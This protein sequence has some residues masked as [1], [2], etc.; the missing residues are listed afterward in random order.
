MTH[1]PIDYTQFVRYAETE[2]PI[3]VV[4]IETTG[5]SMEHEIIELG[6]YDI[7]TGQQWSTYVKPERTRANDTA[8]I[9]GITDADVADAPSIDEA[10]ILLDERAPIDNALFVAHNGHYFDIPRIN[11]ARR[12][13]FAVNGEI[14]PNQV[15]DTL[16]FAHKV[17]PWGGI[18]NYKLQTLIDYYNIPGTQNHRAGDDCEYTAKVLCRLLDT[19]RLQSVP[20]TTVD[21]VIVMSERARTPTPKEKEVRRILISVHREMQR[22]NLEEDTRARLVQA[23]EDMFYNCYNV[24]PDLRSL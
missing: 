6:L 3:Y 17:I 9:T 19:A 16:H 14:R 4:D 11:N 10:L 15:I 22:D 12:K 8:H 5:L 18:L 24:L 13:S 1:T 20:P 21:D 2:Q 23:Y 7:S